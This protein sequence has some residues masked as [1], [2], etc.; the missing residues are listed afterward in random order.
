MNTANHSKEANKPPV[1]RTKIPRAI[2][3]AAESMGIP[4]RQQ[5]E[6]L[7]VR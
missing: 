4:D 1:N 3:A 7:T 2:F 6:Q 5:I